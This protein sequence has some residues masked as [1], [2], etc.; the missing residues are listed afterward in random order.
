ML[1]N[2]TFSSHGTFKRQSSPD[3]YHCDVLWIS[4][5]PQGSTMFS[6]FSE[7]YMKVPET[8]LSVDPLILDLPHL[9]PHKNGYGPYSSKN[10][11]SG[12]NSGPQLSNSRGSRM[13]TRGYFIKICLCLDGNMNSMT[14]ALKLLQTF[15]HEYE[16]VNSYAILMT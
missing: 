9:V 4:G 6:L 11:S 3:P 1:R 10:L 8:F 5:D 14:M 13:L 15:W 7:Y 16:D 12:G 2:Y